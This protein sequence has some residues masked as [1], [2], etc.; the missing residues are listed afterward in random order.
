MGFEILILN[1]A[2]DEIDRAFEY[3]SDIGP[4]VAKK[5]NADL[6]RCWRSLEKN[7][8]FEV[9]HKDYRVVP[10]KKFPFI[11]VYIVDEKRKTVYV[12]SVFHTAQDP[13][14]LP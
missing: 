3:Y 13:D 10:L 1:R 4:E 7:P 2:F 9:R 11:V 5:F 8:F 6:L 14:K 12:Y